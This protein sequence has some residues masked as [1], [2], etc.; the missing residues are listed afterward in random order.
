MLFMLLLQAAPAPAATGDPA[1]R[2]FDL[3]ALPK[4]EVDPCA[5]PV[6]GQAGGAAASDDI[7][8]CGQRDRSPRYMALD[9]P[10]AQKGP[11]LE[12]ALPGGGHVNS[13]VEQKSYG[14]GETAK[15]I[16]LGVTL[17]F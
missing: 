7:V 3:A 5:A 9:D 13:W 14:N 12:Y 11:G 17:P 1:T 10:P 15:R 8:V 2:T 6:G 16:M 4:Q